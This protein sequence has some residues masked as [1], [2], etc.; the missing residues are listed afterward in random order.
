[1][2]AGHPPITGQRGEEKA[3]DRKFPSVRGDIASW[4]RDI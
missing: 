4:A 3:Y 2:H 1:M